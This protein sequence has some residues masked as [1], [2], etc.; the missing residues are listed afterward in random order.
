M[1][2]G[3]IGRLSGRNIPVAQ[4]LMDRKT[5]MALIR[6]LSHNKGGRENEEG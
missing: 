5:A 4:K 2:R 1:D 3:L 6:G